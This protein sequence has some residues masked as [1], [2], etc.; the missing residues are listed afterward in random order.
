LTKN[1]G[2]LHKK[3]KSSILQLCAVARIGEKM[4]DYLQALAIG[5][6]FAVPFLLE[7]LKGLK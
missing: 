5:L 6:I 1:R 4:K 3:L 2:Y 7:I